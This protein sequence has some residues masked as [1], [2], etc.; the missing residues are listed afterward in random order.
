M[1]TLEK[2]FQIASDEGIIID[3]TNKLPQGLKGLHIHLKGIGHVISILYYVKE[4]RD[5]F[6]EILSEELGH[7]FTSVGDNLINV[8][9]YNDYLKVCKC[10]K[11]A[12]NWSVNTVIKN[13]DLE[14]AFKNNC[15]CYFDIAEFLNVP[16][17]LVIEKF[18]YLASK[19][20]NGCVLLGEYTVILTNLPNILIYKDI[21]IK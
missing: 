7:Y 14:R 17:R 5:M 9:S 16:E 20:L 4:D 19:N 13:N 10:E 12:L 3:Y 18:K 11:Q 21:C 8:N 2:L 6:I 15:T 1:D